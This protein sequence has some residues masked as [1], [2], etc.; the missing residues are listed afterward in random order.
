MVTTNWMLRAKVCLAALAALTSA[1]DGASSEE[2]T[3][4]PIG[5]QDG[6]CRPDGTCDGELVCAVPFFEGCPEG[7]GCE[8]HG[9][10]ARLSPGPLLTL[11]PFRLIGTEYARDVSADGQVRDGAFTRQPD[12]SIT[13]LP[14][15]AVGRLYADGRVTDASN[16]LLCRVSDLNSIVDFPP[17]DQR[18]P[19]LLATA[20]GATLTEGNGAALLGIDASN[21]ITGPMLEDREPIEY[22]G[23]PEGRR[24][25]LAAFLCLEYQ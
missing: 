23:P 25:A 4:P 3:V 5:S 24:A 1:C 20:D 11:A 13:P 8:G 12:G 10:R 19:R 9:C 22:T 6:D 21:R 2:P 17:G 14:G 18:R 7:A 15:R 16:R